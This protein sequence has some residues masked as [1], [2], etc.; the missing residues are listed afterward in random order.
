MIKTVKLL[1]INKC[2]LKLEFTIHF[3]KIILAK[4][5]LSS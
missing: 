2:L 3:S 1:K 4:K 5:A